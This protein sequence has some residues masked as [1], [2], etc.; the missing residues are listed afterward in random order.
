MHLAVIM[1]GNGRWGSQRGLERTEGHR[2]G[3]DAL[4]RVVHACLE[5]DVSYLTVYAFSTENWNRPSVE[6]EFLQTLFSTM[7]DRARTEFA[8]LDVRFCLYGRRT[9]P[10][11]LWLREKIQKLEDDTADRKAL[12]LT[13]CYNYGGDQEILDAAFMAGKDLSP[14]DERYAPEA[15]RERFEASLY[16]DLPPVDLLIRTGGEKRLSNFLPWH[17]GY[18]ELMFLDTLWP[19]F[20]PLD[21]KRCLEEFRSRDRRFGRI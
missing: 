18:A 4:E 8:D 14:S 9:D 19:D 1:D 16:G 10:I 2:N 7:I 12:R 15:F 3:A 11:P 13:V 6:T 17:L 5:E 20:T 21:L